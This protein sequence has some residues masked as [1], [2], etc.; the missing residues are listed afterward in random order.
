[1]KSANSSS[2]EGWSSDSKES[3]KDEKEEKSMEKGEEVKKNKSC[4]KFGNF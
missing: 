1:M 4:V 2:C 3:I